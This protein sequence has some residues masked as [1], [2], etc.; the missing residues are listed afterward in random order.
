MS[1]IPSD[2]A[3]AVGIIFFSVLGTILAATNLN[4]LF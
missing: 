2:A 3:K 1:F 4:N